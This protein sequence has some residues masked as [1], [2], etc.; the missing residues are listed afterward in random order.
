MQSFIEKISSYNLF[1]YLL[2]GVL[3][4][5]IMSLLTELD[6]IQENIL[7]GLFLY[8]FIGMIISRFG[9]LFVEPTFLKFGIISYENYS[10]FVKASK[11]DEKV[12]LL[13]EVNNTY[14]SLVSLLFLIILSSIYLLIEDCFSISSGITNYS[15]LSILLILFIF[16]YRKQTGYISKRIKANLNKRDT[17]D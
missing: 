12:S 9:S 1:N 11:E 7:I 2:P 16:S 4:V 17:D 14:R 15:L 10:D 13:S 3:Y 5:G 8:Y 6:L